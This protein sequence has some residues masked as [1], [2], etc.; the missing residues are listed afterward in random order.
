MENSR[1]GSEPKEQVVPVT[2]PVQQQLPD[3]LLE[4]LS[5]LR[6]AQER[7]AALLESSLASA[8][9]N[10]AHLEAALEALHAR[11]AVRRPGPAESIFFTL[12]DA[13]VAVLLCVLTWVI[14]KPTAAVWKL[15]KKVRGVEEKEDNRRRSFGRRRSW[16]L[17]GA[18]LLASDPFL[19]SAAKRLSFTAADLHD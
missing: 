6:K 19:A 4:E 11:A 18:D 16:R 10:A 13:L 17:S 12:L 14:A 9:A 1:P 8:A 5:A 2:P 3:A 7:Q 15:I